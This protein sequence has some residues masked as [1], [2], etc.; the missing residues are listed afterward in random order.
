MYSLPDW[1]FYPLAALVLA[2]MIVVALSFGE[3]STRSTDA[4][5]ADGV[6]YEGDAL[7]GLVTGNGLEVSTLVDDT[8]T[9]A[10]IEAT[11]GPLDGIQSAG[12][13]FALSPNET[14]ALQGHAVRI[15]YTLRS[16]PE[17]G[18]ANT[19]LS[20]FVA[21]IGQDSWQVQPL[22]SEFS[23]H[24]ID[25]APPSCDWGNGY[26]G[27]W[28]DWSVDAN[29]IDVLKVELQVGEAITCG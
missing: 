26:I 24:T 15:V 20:F 25:I 9:F 2:A 29:T 18:A 21:G 27:I 23:E 22:T 6:I 14:Q 28:P 13:F 7:Q 19:R 11:R 5:L 10:R 1:A 4:I 17:N 16:A 8:H 12:A 3:D